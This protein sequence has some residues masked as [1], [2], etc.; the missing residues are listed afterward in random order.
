MTG[1]LSWAAESM[2]QGAF[3]LSVYIQSESRS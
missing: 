2:L 3:D 1:V